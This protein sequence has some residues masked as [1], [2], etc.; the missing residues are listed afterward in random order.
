MKKDKQNFSNEM[1][2]RKK[3]HNPF[4]FKSLEFQNSSFAKHEQ[5]EIS[6]PLIK[7]AIF[8]NG[9]RWMGYQRKGQTLSKIITNSTRGKYF[10]E[11]G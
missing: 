11:R 6:A 2:N 1:V 5:R 10:A 3:R 4:F 8:N 9:L 7:N